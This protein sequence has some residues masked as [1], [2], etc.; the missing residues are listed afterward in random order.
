MQ[1]DI[2]IGICGYASS[3]KL[4]RKCFGG[5]EPFHLFIG[6]R[7]KAPLAAGGRRNIPITAFGG[8]VGHTNFIAAPPAGPFILRVATWRKE[9]RNGI[10]SRPRIVAAEEKHRIDR[11]S[12][13]INVLTT[14]FVH[15]VAIMTNIKLEK[16][17]VWDLIRIW[18]I[19][20]HGTH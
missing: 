6:S 1:L 19:A 3:R 9:P 20:I 14:S 11:R 5:N 10:E 16:P 17:I 13:A 2:A 12:I 15:G 18:G 7:H 8:L 4:A